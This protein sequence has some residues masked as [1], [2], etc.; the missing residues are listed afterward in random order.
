MNKNKI[1]Y[2]LILLLFI[3]ISSASFNQ[4][5]FNV[6]NVNDKKTFSTENNI[7]SQ[8]NILDNT[9][10]ITEIRIKLDIDDNDNNGININ[11]SEKFNIVVLSKKYTYYLIPM[12]EVIMYG[13]YN[14]I[15]FFRDSKN[16]SNL[17]DLNLKIDIKYNIDIE[18]TSILVQPN[19][20]LPFRSDDYLDFETNDFMGLPAS[21]LNIIAN[22][23]FDF[24][25][26]VID[27]TTT[28]SKK[29]AKSELKG[30]SKDLYYLLTIG[31]LFE[32]SSLITMLKLFDSIFTIFRLIFDLLFVFPFLILFW[33][34]IIGNFYTAYKSNNRKEIIFNY[35]EYYK[36][37]C[38][39]FINIMKWVYA[40]IIRIITAI[41]NLIPFT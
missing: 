10:R 11:I 27:Y 12:Q 9:D 28:M 15:T 6:E 8:I 13:Y 35:M 29:I 21:T 5:V 18:N 22:S 14:N 32:S 30:L 34:L 39:I 3:N 7:N 19:L 23:K 24:D 2:L 17:I 33:I 40:S 36:Y 37:I 25:I 26:L 1:F 41:G 16:Y 20:V 31:N 4:T 38:N